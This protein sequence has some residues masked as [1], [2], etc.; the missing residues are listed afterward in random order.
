MPCSLHC[1]IENVKE[2]ILCYESWPLKERIAYRR[3]Q[4]KQ[5]N[6]IGRV[7]LG[8]A[9]RKMQISSNFYDDVK[10]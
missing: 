5:K 8:R 1:R 10:R 6:W 2:C 7:D 4:C 3:A 9:N